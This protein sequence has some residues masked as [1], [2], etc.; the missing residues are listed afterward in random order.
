MN[1]AVI[2]ANRWPVS[3]YNTIATNSS[4]LAGYN[5]AGNDIFIT[6]FTPDCPWGIG[7]LIAAPAW[8]N[9]VT[10]TFTG[11]RA[12]Q[13]NCIVKIVLPS[14]FVVTPIDL[15]SCGLLTSLRIKSEGGTYIGLSG[16]WRQL[17]FSNVQIFTPTMNPTALSSASPSAAPTVSPTGAPSA[18]LSVAPTM[19]PTGA[20]SASPS[21]ART[22]S[23]TGTPS[24]SP[25]AA[26]MTYSN[27]TSA[28]EGDCP[29][30]S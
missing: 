9:N 8:S 21:A 2:G 12:N 30:I 25:S 15:S 5:I 22:M 26:P 3:G 20:P 14:P 4:G 17:G 6:S 19:N 27:S 1:L 29:K 28:D 7:T 16:G 24:S 23:P 13:T 11:A 18:S 10:V